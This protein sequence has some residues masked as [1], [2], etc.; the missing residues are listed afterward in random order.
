M[1]TK[2]PP[3]RK[4]PLK[5]LPHASVDVQTST[6]ADVERLLAEGNVVIV[7]FYATWCGPCKAYS[8][9]FSR[10]DREMRRAVPD[11][12]FAFVSIDVDVQQDLARSARVMS[13]PTTLAWKTGRGLF[14]G[15]K[16]KELM[17]FSGDRP[18]NELLRTFTPVLE[19]HARG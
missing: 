11:G 16:R 19:K 15:E 14:G 8:P 12:K 2:K 13:V 3:P 10:L 17:R 6:A 1:D 7:D 4:R 18:W 9:K 5:T